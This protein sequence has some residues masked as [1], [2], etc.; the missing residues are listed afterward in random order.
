MQIRFSP[1]ALKYM[2]KR[3]ASTVVLDLVDMETGGSVGVVK[4]VAVGFQAPK[5]LKAY[6]YDRVQGVDVYVHRALRIH[7]PIRIKKQ[8]FWKLSS[9]YAD[10][11][12][13][14]I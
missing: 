8:G 4:D 10:G 12:Q 1:G 2:H 6:R 13:V 5:D 7:G 14:P 9:L 3:G 11:L